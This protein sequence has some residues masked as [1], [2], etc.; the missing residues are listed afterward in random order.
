VAGVGSRTLAGMTMQS[1]NQTGDRRSANKDLVDAFIQEL[2]SQG[3]LTAVDRHLAPGFVDHDPPVPGAPSGRE[4]LRQAA[5][6]FRS[7]CPDWH[8]D[9]EQLVEEGDVV[10]ERFTA[11]GTRTGELMGAP[12][13]GEPLELR[14][15]NVF[16]IEDGRIVERWGRLDEAGLARQLGRTG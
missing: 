10:V 4:G 15:I 3:D 1:R 7:A 8:S 11:R 14:G 2:F 9:L 6:S 16:R 12:A 13:T 5:E